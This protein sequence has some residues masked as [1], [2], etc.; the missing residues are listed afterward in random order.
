MFR[1]A[2]MCNI[3]L[4]GVKRGCRGGGNNRPLSLVLLSVKKVKR[5]RL[6]TVSAALCK[7][8]TVLQNQSDISSH[9]FL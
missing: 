2:S 4:M 7:Q 8:L 9:L 1:V 3:A 6:V 5:K